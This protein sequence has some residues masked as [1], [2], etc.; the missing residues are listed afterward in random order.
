[1]AAVAILPSDH[2]VSDDHAFM[3]RVVL[4]FEAVQA[5]PDL[6]VLLG[7]TPATAEP[8]YGWIEPGPPIPGTALLRVR[9][10]HEKPTRAVA[11]SLLEGHCLWNSFVMVARV[12]ALFAVIREATPALASAFAPLRAALG[13][14]SERA[15][16]RAVYRGLVSSSFAADVLATRPSNLAVL[17][18]TGVEWSDWGRPERVMTTLASLGIRPE[19][20]DR[21][22]MSA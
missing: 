7:I 3:D 19:W 12:P 5:R 4:A 20:A 14:A 10:F 21:L 16:V 11:E 6:V 15:A 22:P 1:M 13:T 8:E 18:V 9:R 2:Y 17:P